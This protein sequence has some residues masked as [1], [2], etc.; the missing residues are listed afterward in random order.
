MT[1]LDICFI[2]RGQDLLMGWL[3]GVREERQG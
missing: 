2:S 3:K 1:M